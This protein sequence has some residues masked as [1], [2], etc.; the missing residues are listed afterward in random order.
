MSGLLNLVY[1]KVNPSG[2]LSESIAYRLEDYPATPYFLKDDNIAE[3]RESIFVGYRYFNT[4]G[5]KVRYPFGYG[6][7]Y[8]KFS[9]EVVKL[10]DTGITVRI[11]TLE[12]ILVRM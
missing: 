3:Y 1:G 4:R 11:K 6:L 8:T 5:V 7:S 12:N 9:K 10:D 2:R